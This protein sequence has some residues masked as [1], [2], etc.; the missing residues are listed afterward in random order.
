M[1]LVP[2]HVLLRVDVPPFVGEYIPRIYH[3]YTLH[4]LTFPDLSAFQADLQGGTG[5]VSLDLELL[6]Q[7]WRSCQRGSNAQRLLA[8]Y[9]WSMCIGSTTLC[10]STCQTS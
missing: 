7:C 2:G 3:S 8:V 4:I 9:G 1:P 6:K 5:A 10:S